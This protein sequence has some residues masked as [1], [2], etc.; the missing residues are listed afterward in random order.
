MR[1][2]FL[3]HNYPRHAGDVAGAFLHTLAVA[4]K[5]R[6]IDVRVVA[7]SDEGKGG[8]T[9]LDGIPVRRVR[10]GDAETETLAYRGTMASAIKTPQG[11]RSLVRL[12]RA[13]RVG[14]I[15][16]LAGADE[17]VLHAHWW[18]PAG[19]AAPATVP[20]VITCHGTDVRL[21]ER[22]L[23]IRWLGRRTLRRA[24]VVTTVSQPWA[25]M[26]ER[27]GGVHVPPDRVQP[28]PV[29]DV[30]RPWSTGGGGVVVIGRLSEQKRVDLAI[31]GYADARHRGIAAPLTIV[32]DG[33][34]RDALQVLV[35][36]LGLNAAVRFVGEVPPSRIPEFLATADCCLMTAE[37][38]GLGLTAAEAL[39][40]G[41]PVVACRD[42]GGVLDVVPAT[43]A[44]R[45]VAPVAAAISVGLR[46]LLADP[47]AR[48]AAMVEGEEWRRRLSPDFVAERCLGWY[49]QALHG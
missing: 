13:F 7:P 5:Q 14:A 18:F 33:P 20:V 23:F 3:T 6:G 19:V 16:E 47:A 21:L 28:M 46:D 45:V 40:Q 38:E 43:G 30:A 4:L 39:M 35:E 24:R 49:Q 34:T 11:L 48:A 1:A 22:G 41:V 27:L 32:G 26:L 12:N 42:G 37:S 8:R 31:G 9:E 2:V 17:A 10:Y 25:E 36:G 15:A 44:G 29:T